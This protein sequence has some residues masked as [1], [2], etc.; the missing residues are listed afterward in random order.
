[1]G[2]TKKVGIVLL[3]W[4]TA[5]LSVA[6]RANN[7]FCELQ[8]PSVYGLAYF[9]FSPDCKADRVRFQADN[10]AGCSTPPSTTLI[11]EEQDGGCHQLDP[12]DPNSDY[13]NGVWN[14]RPE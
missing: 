9:Y 13:H 3:L 11:F 1:M 8:D 7:C 10:D 4:A 14:C 6:S 5:T 12:N 2:S